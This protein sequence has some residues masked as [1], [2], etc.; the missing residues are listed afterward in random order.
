MQEF[1]AADEAGFRRGVGIL[2]PHPV[3]AE[4]LLRSFVTS[5][6][7]E[8]V[9]LSVGWPPTPA[10]RACCDAALLFAVRGGYDFEARLAW[11]MDGALDFLSPD[12]EL[13]SGIPERTLVGG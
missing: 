3:D 1:R 9:V 2:G 5:R 4:A 13:L 6:R 11:S 8:L 10:Q 7:P 12:D